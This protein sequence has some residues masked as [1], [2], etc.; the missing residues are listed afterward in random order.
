M[1]SYL[2]RV[3]ISDK[4]YARISWLVKPKSVQG[5]LYVSTS[6]D[7]ATSHVFVVMSGDENNGFTRTGCRLAMTSAIGDWVLN[8]HI[9]RLDDSEVLEYATMTGARR[10]GIFGGSVGHVPI[11]GGDLPDLVFMK[12]R[13]GDVEFSA[14]VTVFL[15]KEGEATT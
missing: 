14:S 7:A 13:G 8:S 2:L 4:K 9:E 6:F 5:L 12:T 1:R 15:P 10:F 11:I 3:Q